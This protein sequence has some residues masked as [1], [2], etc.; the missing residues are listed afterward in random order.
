MAARPEAIAVETEAAAQ[1]DLLLIS[2]QIGSSKAFLEQIDHQVVTHFVGLIECIFSAPGVDTTRSMVIKNIGDSLMVRLVCAE[3]SFPELLFRI[4][5]KVNAL[6][7]HTI[8]SPVNLRILLIPLISETDFKSGEE[9]IK[10][11]QATKKA[12]LLANGHLA[13]FIRLAGGSWDKWMQGDLFGPKINL[14]FRAANLS[15]HDPIV[16]VEDSIVNGL[17]L[18]GNQ[19]GRPFDLVVS[20][21]TLQLGRRLGFTPIRGLEKQYRPCKPNPAA[22]WDGHLFLRTVSVADGS[23]KRDPLEAEQEKYKCFTR[24]VWKDFPKS[25]DIRNW[26]REVQKDQGRAQY[27]R[28]ISRVLCEGEVRR[29]RRASRN[30]KPPSWGS[31][32]VHPPHPH[33]YTG[34]FGI[35][36]GPFE[37]TYEL[38]RD[39]ILE[40]RKPMVGPG[41]TSFSYLVSTTVFNPG[42]DEETFWLPPQMEEPGWHV[43]V[44]WRWLP[45]HRGRGEDDGDN[46]V[47]GLLRR[48]YMSG[49]FKK[50]RHGMVVGG[51]WDGY[52][53]LDPVSVPISELETP[54]GLKGHYERFLGAMRDFANDSHEHLAAE[55][56]NAAFYFCCDPA[57]AVER[58]RES[59]L[60]DY[61][62]AASQS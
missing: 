56:E 23:T 52:A 18:A 14:A 62:Q 15:I 1:L 9:I 4:L 37:S 59:D 43:V 3:S 33:I 32:I 60:T 35:F 57:V 11:L 8:K 38:L 7:E 31:V 29:Q 26:A 46:L 17:N 22:G 5:S 20:G 61:A 45:E 39:N 51:E 30:G 16:I 27:F 12:E 40:K 10:D 2:D 6:A 25:S 41:T 19:D 42:E 44:F 50:R 53:L 28:D 24:F 48:S 21:K 58:L 49:N 13:N 34:L 47:R 55:V 36:A 54:D